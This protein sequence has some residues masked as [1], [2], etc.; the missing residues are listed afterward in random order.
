M[1]ELIDEFKE[2]RIVFVRWNPDYYKVNNKRGS[3]SRQQR[4]EMLK[5]L[6]IYLC[7]K[8]D[9]QEHEHIMIYYMFYSQDNDAIVNRF[10]KKFIYEESDF[11]T[12]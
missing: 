6:I 9:W 3:K 8:R 4:L 5:S 11:L 10:P 12:P 1:D 2:G 7:E